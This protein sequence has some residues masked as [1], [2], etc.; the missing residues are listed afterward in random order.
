MR[1]LICLILGLLIGAV[2]ASMAGNVLAKRSAYPKGLMVVMQ[3]ALKQ[4]NRSASQSPCI[5]NDPD[6][7][8]LALLANDIETAMPGDGTPDRVFHLY[9]EDMQRITKAAAASACPQR[10]DMLTRIKGACDSCHR[11]YR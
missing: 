5:D 4:A 7:T 6:L 2:C 8:K 1:Y 9:V 11:D 3:H 10:T